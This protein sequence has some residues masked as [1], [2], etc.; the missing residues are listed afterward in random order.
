LSKVQYLADRGVAYAA[1]TALWSP[2]QVSI[3]STR[4]AET[5]NVNV[6]NQRIH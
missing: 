3:N 1:Y 2:T 6:K 5:L 4:H